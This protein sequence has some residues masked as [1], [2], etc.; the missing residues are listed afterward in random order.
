MPQS[1]PPPGL[2]QVPFTTDQF[3]SV[4]RQ[5]NEA[6][7]PAQYLLVLLAVAAVAVLLLRRPWAGVL[8]SS[9]LAFLWAWTGIAYHLTFFTS[10]NP[11]AYAFAAISMIGAA[12][13]AWVGVVK[14][15]LVFEVGVNARSAMAAVLVVFALLVYPAWATL[16]GH[17]Y[18][19]LPTFGLPCPTT[20]FT[21]GLLTLASGRAA[22]WALG[23]P[24]VWSLIGGQAAF[25]LDVPPDSGLA[26]AG[27]FAVGLLFRR[28]AARGALAGA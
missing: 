2:M 5:Y 23:A 17:A 14:R 27:L 25:L 12:V 4:I 28:P 21:I 24:I 3:F 8:V 26:A 11:L 1:Q 6:V 20:I 7:W 10:I 18:P 22:K 15:R 16:A 9:V 19:D 13:L